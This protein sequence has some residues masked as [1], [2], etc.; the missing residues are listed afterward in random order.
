M[1]ALQLDL[2]LRDFAIALFL[3][4]LVGIEREKKQA[5]DPDRG[6]GGLRTFMLFAEAGAVA[7][8][9]SLQLATP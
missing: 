3:G 5:A 2:P 8:W 4:A 6:I 7:A 9:L 1:D